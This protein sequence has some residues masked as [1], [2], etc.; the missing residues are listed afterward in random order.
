MWVIQPGH[1][2]TQ[3]L[4]M[5]TNPLQKRLKGQFCPPFV[6][7]KLVSDWKFNK[8]DPSKGGGPI[9][10]SLKKAENRIP[11]RVGA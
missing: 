10:W 6:E 9:S 5:L 3:Q 8:T 4:E 2:S 1:S 7:S 11:S